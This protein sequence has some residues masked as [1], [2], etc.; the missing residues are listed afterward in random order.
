[1]SDQFGIHPKEVV[2]V[3]SGKLGFSIKGDKRYQHFGDESDIDIAIVS[4]VLFDQIWSE[5]FR[6]RVGGAFWPEERDFKNYLFRGWLRPDKLPPDDS[7]EYGRKWW[8]FLRQLETDGLYGP[9]KIRAG[10]YK[11]WHFLES[12]QTANVRGCRGDLGDQS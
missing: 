4:G 2:V 9:Y 5:V 6:Y 8:R 3:G 7:F 12:Y 1:M 11:S 10:I